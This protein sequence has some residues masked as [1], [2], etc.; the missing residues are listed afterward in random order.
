[1]ILLNINKAIIYL[2]HGCKTQLHTRS[3]GNTAALKIKEQCPLEA[4]LHSSSKVTIHECDEGVEPPGFWEAL[5]RKDRKAYDCMLQDPGKFNFTPRLFQLTSTS[6]EFVAS[7]FFHLSRA[8]DLVSSLPFLQED[9][10]NTAQPA[11]FLVDNFHEVYLWQ[12]WWPQDSECTGSARIRWDADRKCAMETV[13]QYCKEKN[14]KKPQKSYLIHAGLEPLTFTNMFPSWEHR[15]D[16]AEITEREA[17]VCNQII[18]VEDVLARLCQNTFPLAQLQARP[19]PEG[20]D[21]LRLEIYLSDQDFEKALE[22]KREEYE[23]LPGWKQVNLKKAKG[24]F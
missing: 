4:G 10:Y 3:V 20:V 16:V 2:W 6:G 8:P 15:E 21:P 12:G 17:E 18:L 14:E 22:M 24:L 1:M 7:E 5:G 23:S 13:L 9:L 19:L 11:L